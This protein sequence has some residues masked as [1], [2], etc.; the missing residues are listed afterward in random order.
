MRAGPYELTPVN[1]G[2]FALDGGAMFG[3]VP[4]VL[5]EKTNPPDA[6]NRI[7]MALRTLLIRGEGRTI[8]VDTG[9]GA[10]FPDKQAE[11]F[12]V[13]RRGEGLLDGL[14]ALGV[15]PADVTDV[16]ISHLHFDHA[17]GATRRDATGTV[18][19]TFPSAAIHVQRANL[20][21]A[22]CPNERERASYLAE[23]VE[24]L[25]AAGHLVRHEGELELAPGVRLVPAEGHTRGMQAVLVSVPGCSP[26]FYPA[27]L[28]PTSSHLKIPWVMGYDLWPLTVMEEKKRLLARA[29]AEDWIVV[30]E[31]DPKLPACR[32]GFDG[33]NYTAREPVEMGS[34]E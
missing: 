28:I 24:P 21:T 2:R 12:N 32:V 29:V 5:W 33:K 17:G 11:M 22:C 20:E 31:H 3:T 14:L 23:N 34:I 8:L 9:I 25:A 13:R 6:K 27:D 7:D 16:V 4:R 19:P 10:K 26:V 15:R 18:V 30:F 1:D